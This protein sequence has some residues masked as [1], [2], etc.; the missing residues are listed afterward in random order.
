MVLF[1]FY[2]GY[3]GTYGGGMFS[4]FIYWLDYWGVRDII[5]PF[6]LIFTIFFAVL[7]KIELFGAGKSKKYN[8][9]ISIAIALLTVIPHLTG[10]Y[11]PHADVINI[12]NE[13]IPQTALLV[14]VVV[15]VLMM[16][17]LVGGEAPKKTGFTSLL[18]I[19]GVLLLLAIFANTLF[20]LPLINY[21][22]PSIQALIVILV[23]FGLIVWYVTRETPTAGTG[24]GLRE[25]LWEETGGARPPAASGGGGGGTN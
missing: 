10:M 20:P 1:Q 21:I 11:P 2:G 3:R 6:I 25:W 15:L 24:K 7:Q 9:A 22:D 13:S 8:V 12:I 16:V 17:G 19:V 5:L 4:D 14:V 18:A 23:V